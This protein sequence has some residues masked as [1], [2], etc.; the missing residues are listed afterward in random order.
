MIFLGLDGENLA[1]NAEE[2][3]TM[4]PYDECAPYGD[5]N[6]DGVANVGDIVLQVNMVLGLMAPTPC[7][8]QTGDGQLNVLDVIAIVNIIL[9]SP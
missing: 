3:V 7:A 2:Y 1:V 8:D 9:S 6:G 5:V 4:P